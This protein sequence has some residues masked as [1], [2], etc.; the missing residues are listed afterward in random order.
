MREAIKAVF[1]RA[2]VKKG[3]DNCKNTKNKTSKYPEEFY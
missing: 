3:N 2:E 1:T